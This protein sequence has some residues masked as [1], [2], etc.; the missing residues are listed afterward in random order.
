MMI[1]EITAMVGRYKDR[2]RVGRGESSGRGKTAGR[3]HKGAASRAGWTNRANFEGGQMQ[4]FRRMPKRGFSNA[5]FR[6]D[7][8]IVNL[9][10]LEKTFDDGSE[11]TPE[12]LA[13]RGLIRS[14]SQPVKILGQ[15]SLSKRLTVQAAKF[16]GSAREK[17]EAAGGTATPTAKAAKG[18]GGKNGASKPKKS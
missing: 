11:I 1:H 14:A 15:G 12:A 2:K 9:Q 13:K 3:G 4:F 17:I 16:S 6:T 8:A 5:P 10:A 18:R 7:Y